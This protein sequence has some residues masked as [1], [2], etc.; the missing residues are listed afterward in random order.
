MRTFG[1]VKMEKI[2][3]EL[4]RA[5]VAEWLYTHDGA[6]NNKQEWREQL[7]EMIKWNLERVDNADI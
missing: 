2:S 5:N 6:M 1:E 4:A 3:V 7:L